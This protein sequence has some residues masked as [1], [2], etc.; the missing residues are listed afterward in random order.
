MAG[1]R[2]LSGID[3]FV[4]SDIQVTRGVTVRRGELGTV[5]GQFD[6]IM[7]HHSLEHVPDPVEVVSQA[8]SLLAP[9]G[10]ILI[11]VPVMGKWAWRQYGT[12]WVQLDAPRHLHLFTEKAVHEMADSVGLGVDAVIYDSFEL[13]YIG[14]EKVRLSRANST[15][16]INYTSGDIRSFRRR[17][18]KLNINHDGDQACFLMRGFHTRNTSR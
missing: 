9:G 17:A 16:R 8:A 2:N 6:L 11:H 3:P 1:F 14:S 15:A 12:D 5:Q 7:F 13:Q 4:D 10:W 18:R